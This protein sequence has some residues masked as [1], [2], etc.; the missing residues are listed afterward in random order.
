MTPGKARHWSRTASTFGRHALVATLS[1]VLSLASPAAIVAGDPQPANDAG[2]GVTTTQPPGEAEVATQSSTTF[3]IGDV[4][5]AVSD[6]R[7]QWRL[8]DG[9]LNSTLDTGLAGYTT[10][11]AFDKLGNL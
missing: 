10:G 7:V 3:G 2:A 6:G 4:F 8:P 1:V 11:M 9:T 5:V